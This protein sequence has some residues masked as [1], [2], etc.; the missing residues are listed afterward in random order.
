MADK[1]KKGL[2][3]EEDVCTILQRYPAS[4]VLALLKEV[5]QLEDVNIDWHALIEKTE[6]GIKSAREYQMLW[7]FLAYRHPLIDYISPDESPLDD[8]SDLEFEVECPNVSTVDAMDA[9]NC[10]KVL[11]S[12]AHK[13]RT[14]NNSM[15]EVSKASSENPQIQ[16]RSQA[17]GTLVGGPEANGSTSHNLKK[18]KHLSEE[19]DLELIPNAKKGE[20]KGEK[21]IQRFQKPNNIRKKPVSHNTA[22]VQPPDIDAARHALKMALKDSPT[23]AGTAGS[24]NSVKISASKRNLS[25]VKVSG[26]PSQQQPSPFASAGASGKA[27]PIGSLSKFSS[28]KKA[29][30]S[31][32]GED[33]IQAA[34]VA[35]GARIGSDSDAAS[36]RK[37]ELLVKTSGAGNSSPLPPNVHFICTGLAQTP[38][39]GSQQTRHSAV[40]PSVSQLAK[41]K[42]TPAVAGERSSFQQVEN[43]ASTTVNIQGA[44]PKLVTK[45]GNNSDPNTQCV[46][47]TS[48]DNK[49]QATSPVERTSDLGNFRDT[50]NNDDVDKIR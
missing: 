39:P 48:L 13:S 7:R 49:C 33:P 34:A 21:S 32:V 50:T 10:V 30:H 2:I 6:T 24:N 25:A 44:D 46:A 14:P 41:V 20:T 31:S 8:E 5:N 36:L 12:G 15:F 19:E 45:V 23:G 27:A 4:T 29:L 22:G 9:S 42:S 40:G 16:K 26:V 43:R 18:R 35:A 28:Q 3:T 1:P 47:K 37:A 38:T 17:A 11:T